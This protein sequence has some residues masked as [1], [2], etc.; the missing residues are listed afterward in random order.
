MVDANSTDMRARSVS[1][2]ER[3]KG[4]LGGSVP[5]GHEQY[6]DRQVC[7]ARS[8]MIVETKERQRTV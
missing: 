7:T 3:G 1:E 4:I 2:G 8:A 5:E 6:V